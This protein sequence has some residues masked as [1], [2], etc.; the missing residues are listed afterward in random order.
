M[1][2]AEVLTIGIA[3]AFDSLSIAGFAGSMTNGNSDALSDIDI[4]IIHENKMPEPS[5]RR[6]LYAVCDAE[7]KWIDVDFE[8]SR[9]DG[10]MLEGKRVDFIHMEETFVK[11]YISNLEVDIECDEFLPGG[12]LSLK[13]IIDKN[14]GLPEIRSRIQSYPDGRARKR[15]QAFLSHE[16]FNIYTLQWF[17]KAIVRNDEYS[18]LKNMFESLDRFMTVIHAL[19]RT[20]YSNEKRLI[21]K[22]HDFQHCPAN[23]SG[24][25]HRILS[26]DGEFKSMRHCTNGII[27]LFSE[28]SRLAK[29]VFDGL[30]VPSEWRMV[31]DG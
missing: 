31:T 13:P 10:I 5:M 24:R 22:L 9:G 29:D 19:N 16:Y 14:N 17:E 20:W 11:E 3:K 28:L 15:T 7:V 6:K 18:F 26:R 23:A 21:A 1:N 30:A 2:K 12:L 25:I 4:A 27:K 8:V